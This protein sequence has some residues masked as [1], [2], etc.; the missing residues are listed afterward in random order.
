M[1]HL[2][3]NSPTSAERRVNG[4]NKISLLL[5]TLAIAIVVFAIMPIILH[6]SVDV[7]PTNNAPHQLMHQL[8]RATITS[9]KRNGKT[10]T[11]ETIKYQLNDEEVFNFAY[12][13]EHMRDIPPLPPDI[14]GSGRFLLLNALEKRS[15]W[16]DELDSDIETER[17]RKYF[18]Y[19]DGVKH[20]SDYKGRKRR[21]LFLGSLIADD[22]WHALGALAMETYGVY[23]AV[24]FVESNRTQ[25]GT[26]RELRF[27]NGTVDHTIL[28]E[29]NLF[30]PNTT[31]MLDYFS[32]EGKLDA[33]HLVREQMQRS[34]IIDMWKRAGMTPDDIGVITDADET[35]TRDMLRAAQTCD[36][37]HLNHDTQNCHTAKLIVS[38][39]VFE[40]SP[41]CMTVTRD[42][43]HPDLILG[44]C[45]EGI[46][47]DEFKL[48]DSQRQRKFAWRKK[49]YTH[50]FGNYSGWPKEKT[51]E[52]IA[53]GTDTIHQYNSIFILIQTFLF[54]EKSFP[55]MECSRFS[56]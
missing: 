15:V 8:R 9:S 28:M 18:S 21:R 35:P 54:C 56:T 42:W 31:V 22:S 43:M 19:T 38:S 30:G 52:Y 20:F 24:A 3:S 17:C 6:H 41:E 36:F 13:D 2:S 12:E 55:T 34:L 26:P 39:M 5:T 29:S 51:S 4:I 37:P 25:T 27:V 46:G 45:I 49:P 53:I 50:K 47:D 14:S 1:H 16:D 23:T 7:R 33:G 32:F 40:G 10:S 11:I 44:K 48:D